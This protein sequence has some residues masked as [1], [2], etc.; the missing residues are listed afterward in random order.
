MTAVTKVCGSAGC[1]EATLGEYNHCKVHHKEQDDYAYGLDAD[2]KAKMD[3]KYDSSRER[4]AAQWLAT[5]TG[6]AQG[7]AS[8]Q[9]WLK[10]GVVLCEAINK[11]KSGTVRKINK[12]KMPFVQRENVSNYLVGCRDLG[13]A[14]VTLFVTQDLF[15]GQNMISVIDN[16]FGVCALARKVGF[17]GPFIGKKLADKNVRE[18]SEEVIRKGKSMMPRITQGSYGYQPEREKKLDKIILLDRE[19]SKA[20]SVPSRQNIASYG[21]QEEKQNFDSI[22]RNGSKPKASG[23][24][25]SSPKNTPV[26]SSSNFCPECGTKSDGSKFCGECGNK[27]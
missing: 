15:E 18:F 7:D 1:N 21:L 19:A 2:I 5:I 12:G 11:I 24:N 23:S 16:I 9:E 26:T 20:S 4:E 10:S 22:T 14:E 6:I 8:F 13:M 27:M 3:L 25:S 17:A